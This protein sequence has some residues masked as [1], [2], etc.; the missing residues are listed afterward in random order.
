MCTCIKKRG[1]EEQRERER[2]VVDSPSVD[3]LIRSTGMSVFAPRA[4]S[5]TDVI[6]NT[7]ISYIHKTTAMN[8]ND[9]QDKS[10]V[11]ATHSKR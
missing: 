11:A 8:S 2:E 3:H 7:N 9:I 10:L 4:S 5:L 1:E 6:S